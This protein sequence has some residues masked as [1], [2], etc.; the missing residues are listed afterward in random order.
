MEK[1]ALRFLGAIAVILTLLMF[2]YTMTAALNGNRS[3]RPQAETSTVQ[4]STNN[5]SSPKNSSQTSQTFDPESEKLFP[6]Q[7]AQ[8]KRVEIISGEEALNSVSMLHGKDIPIKQAYVANYQGQGNEQMTIW[9]SETNNPQDAQSLFQSMD[10]KMPNTNA[11]KDYKT[12][13]LDNRDY[14]FVTG[15]GQDH[16][17]WLKDNRVLWLAVQGRDSLSILKEVILLY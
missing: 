13:T 4:K 11:F 6:S 2:A 1:K 8:M 5:Q 3:S 9:Y 12:V 15:M 17:Y 14:K 7:L 10:K 16:Y